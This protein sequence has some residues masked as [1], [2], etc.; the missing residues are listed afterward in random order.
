MFRSWL[1][2][3]DKGLACSTNELSPQEHPFWLCSWHLATLA[4]IVLLS[5]EEVPMFRVFAP[6]VFFLLA[7]LLS[8]EARGQ[9][10]TGPRLY[11]TV[12]P[13]GQYNL[14]VEPWEQW[15]DAEI[16]VRGD[17]SRDVGPAAPGMPVEI[18]G[19]T[20]LK[21]SLRV[22]IY[23]AIQGGPGVTWMLEVDPDL[24]PVRPPLVPLPGVQDSAAG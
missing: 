19:W 9:G 3:S 6:T 18:R 7:S 16:T 5:W 13:D 24:V 1:A 10:V 20:G 17:D 11:A 15:T 14:V 12:A 2:C 4:C 23:A 21:G 22:T 8:A